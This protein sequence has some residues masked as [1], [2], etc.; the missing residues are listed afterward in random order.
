MKTTKKIMLQ[1]SELP[2]QWYNIM[3]DMPTK[4]QPLLNPGTREPLLPQEM[5]GLFAKGLVEQE[6]SE[7]RWHDIPDEVLQLY[8]IYRPTPL[9][10]AYGLEKALDTPKKY[11]SKMRA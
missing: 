2:K 9:V 11:T 6:F 5:E 4:P 10:R 3:A 1:E 7:K 8:K